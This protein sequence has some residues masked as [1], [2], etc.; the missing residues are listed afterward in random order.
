MHGQHRFQIDIDEDLAVDDEARL[1]TAVRQEVGHATDT[2][3][4]AQKLGLLRVANIDAVVSATAQR[5]GDELAQVEQVDADLGDTKAAQ[6]RQRIAGQRMIADGE[7]RLGQLAPRSFLGGSTS[8]R[9]APCRVAG[10]Q[11]HPA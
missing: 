11:R 7:Q 6:K 3:A 5:L 4:G 10:F 8:R 2:A 1:A 9:T